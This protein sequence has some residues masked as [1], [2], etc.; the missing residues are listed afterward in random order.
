MITKHA[1]RLIQRT[2]SV[3]HYGKGSTTALNTKTIFHPQLQL[4]PPKFLGGTTRWF[5]TES[6]YH[7]RADATLHTIQD[8]LD[9]YFEDNPDFG[10]PD[11]NYASG[12]LTIALPQGT[13]VMNKQSP[14]RQIWWSS[15]I[16]GPRRYEYDADD[17]KWIW[18]RYV[19]FQ[20]AIQTGKSEN[21]A[22]EWTDTKHLGEALKR[23][24]IDIFHLDDGLDDLDDL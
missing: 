13:W 6:E 18:T 15:P 19:D 10:S 3:R 8:T 4:Q 21:V 9:F 1:T 22:G 11:I 16:S 7:D 24:M 20:T 12:V 2:L 23:E 14:N 17:G 5:R